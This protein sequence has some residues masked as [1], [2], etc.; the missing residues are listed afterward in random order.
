MDGARPDPTTNLEV[1]AEW[2]IRRRELEG[3]TKKQALG[4]EANREALFALG[5]TL[6]RKGAEHFC[7]CTISSWHAG[8]SS[9]RS[10]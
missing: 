5:D 1:S 2:R 8:R 7:Y 3:S 9:F 6:T 4:S 10:P